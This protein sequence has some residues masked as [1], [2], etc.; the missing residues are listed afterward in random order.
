MLFSA[1][2]PP[3]PGFSRQPP[4]GGLNL[5]I[6]AYCLAGPRLAD[7]L[8]G[9]PGRGRG[10]ACVA[11]AGGSGGSGGGGGCATARVTTPRVSPS[12]EKLVESVGEA[13]VLPGGRG[14]GRASPHLRPHGPFWCPRD[15]PFASDVPLTPG[16][17]CRP[18]ALIFCPL[19]ILPPFSLFRFWSPR[20]LPL[21]SPS[22]IPVSLPWRLATLTP[23]TLGTSGHPPLR[24]LFQPLFVQLLCGLYCCSL[25]PFQITPRPFV[26]SLRIIL[27]ILLSHCFPLSTSAPPPPPPFFTVLLLLSLASL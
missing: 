2:P 6:K 4:S 18:S 14:P 7:G 25:H 13:E 11:S 24:R 3:P 1:P 8:S 27:P 16:R 12:S 21:P 10:V 23:C 9:G 15:G 22:L 19:L 26:P 5:A 20:P 17:P